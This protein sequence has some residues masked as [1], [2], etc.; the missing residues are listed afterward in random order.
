MFLIGFALMVKGGGM[1]VDS[2]ADIAEKMGIPKFIVGAT[3]V[4]LAT[5]CPELTV[6]VMAVLNGSREMGIGNAMGSVSCNIGIALAICILFSAIRINMKDFF[7]KG[8]IMIASAAVMLIF[9]ADKVLTKGESVFLLIILGLFFWINIDSA[10][11]ERKSLK[12][13]SREK[14]SGKTLLLF[15]VGAAGIIIGARFL[16]EGGQQIARML[17]VPEKIIG[18]TLIAVGTSLP[19]IVTA[20]ISASKGESGMSVGN[21]VGA[22]IIDMTLILP[23]CSFISENGLAVEESVVRSDIPAAL[24]LCVIAVLP[25]VFM[26][27]FKKW[28]A[29]VLAGIYAGY[30]FTAVM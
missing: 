15:I 3:V 4:S 21:I 16:V 1:F 14:I 8:I 10:K 7:A 18:I 24:A 28:Q 25:A 12:T 13:K 23:V 6:S 11:N 22:N 26:K 29:F 30:I 5:T 19:E 9:A 20:I 17:N 2:A 27:G